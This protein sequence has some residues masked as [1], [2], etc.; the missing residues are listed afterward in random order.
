LLETDWLI[1]PAE[2]QIRLRVPP[3][4]TVLVDLESLNSPLLIRITI[5]RQASSGMQVGDGLLVISTG[6]HE[7]RVQRP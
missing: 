1:S 5:K 3:A 4:T 7:I 6:N 2:F